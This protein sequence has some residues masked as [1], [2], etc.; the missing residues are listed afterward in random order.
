MGLGLGSHELV[1]KWST[2]EL[3]AGS[4]VGVRLKLRVRRRVRLRVS[5]RAGRD[6]PS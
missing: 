2:K 3:N 5:V 4:T 6:Q 1:K